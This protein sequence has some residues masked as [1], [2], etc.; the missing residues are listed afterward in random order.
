M[1]RPRILTK[2]KWVKSLPPIDFHFLFWL[3]TSF[4]SRAIL[5]PRDT[6]AGG[7]FFGEMSINIT[8]APIV[9]PAITI[10]IK[11][12]IWDIPLST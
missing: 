1:F 4:T 2:I 12:I 3:V 5:R 8:I 7:N 6:T 9:K 11:K 10:I